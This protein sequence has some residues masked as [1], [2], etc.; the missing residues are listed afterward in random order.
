MKKAPAD[1]AIQWHRSAG[2]R[3]L[4]QEDFGTRAPHVKW[5]SKSEQRRKWARSEEGPAEGA[6]TVKNPRGKAGGQ[7][8]RPP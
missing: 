8:P 4:R 5:L 7:E 3:D 2:S 1:G 6:S